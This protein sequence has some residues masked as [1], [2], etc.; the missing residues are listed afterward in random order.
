MSEM[1]LDFSQKQFLELVWGSI[2]KT[3]FERSPDLS[4]TDVHFVW[5]KI[6]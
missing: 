3:A 5:F 1:E 6:L 2:L 4:D